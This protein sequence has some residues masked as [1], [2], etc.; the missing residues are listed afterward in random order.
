MGHSAL[1]HESENFLFPQVGEGEDMGPYMDQGSGD[2]LGP[3]EPSSPFEGQ[4]LFQ[5]SEPQMGHGT[6]GPELD[7]TQT[8]TYEPDI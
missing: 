2:H 6:A 8:Q 1:S 4:E 5:D 3:G 7:I